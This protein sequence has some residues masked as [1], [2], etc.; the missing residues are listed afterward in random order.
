MP[1]LL[2]ALPAIAAFAAANAGTIAATGLVAAGT[3]VSAMGA[4]RQG[5]VAGDTAMVNA[6]LRAREQIGQ[7]QMSE[8]E[9]QVREQAA[10]MGERQATLSDRTAGLEREYTAEDVMRQ[11]V[12]ARAFQA[13]QRAAVGGSGLEA[14]GSPLMV[15]AESAHQLELDR[16]VT[17]HEGE[18]R[19]RAHE[20]E[21]RLGREDATQARHGAELARYTARQQRQGIPL[22]LEIGRYQARAS[23]QAGQL[24][25][26]SAL[27]GGGSRAVGA[28]YGGRG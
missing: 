1:P 8:Y 16:M 6:K 26:V 27:I 25:A 21:A 11:R 14:T 13:E 2:V 9:A 15:M 12:Q 4:L 23:R 5:Q 7:A 24:G 17:T 18:M 3:A 10:L 22:G 19:A 28:F 20:E